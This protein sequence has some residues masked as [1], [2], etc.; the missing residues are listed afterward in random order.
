MTAEGPG[1]GTPPADGWVFRPAPGWPLPPPGWRPPPGWA[2]S[3]TWPPAPAGWQF[4]VPVAPSAPPAGRH[5]PLPAPDGGPPWP[6]PSGPPAPPWPPG[7]WPAVGP[8]APWPQPWPV[9]PPPIPAALPVVV[10][11]Q[12]R[13]HL[14]LETWFVMV[15]FLA[16]VVAS[17]VVAFVEH[18]YSAG[19]TDERLPDLVPGHQLV[20][21]V[22][23][24]VG[25]VPL[26]ALVPLALYL[27]TRTGQPPSSIGLSW[28]PSF[29]ED[30]WPGLGLAAASFGTEFALLIP[31]AP[32]LEH[33]S[34]LS[35]QVQIGHVPHYYVLWGL[36]IT[37]TTSV[38]EEVLVNGYLITRLQQLD[39]TP[40]A[41][42]L[43]SLALRTSY[44]VYYGVGFLLTI[45]FGYFVTRSFQKHRRLNRSIAAHVLFDGVLFTISIL[46]S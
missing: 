34:R 7:V 39:W 19:G 37:L 4:W 42:L 1:A 38:T 44:H 40:R 32:V 2:P 43:L 29:A 33:G 12:T 27:L 13:R 22:L 6:P 28:R 3:P 11:P 18:F 5:P 35:N 9:G 17:A 25:Y 14:V 15:A 21:L 46:A 23:G 36:V 45:P 16:P 30:I 26:A 41:A 20:T 8:P 31:L 24:I 10:A